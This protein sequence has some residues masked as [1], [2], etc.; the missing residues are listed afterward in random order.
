LLRVNGVIAAAIIIIHL[1]EGKEG[2]KER[3]A[4]KQATRVDFVQMGSLLGF[5]KTRVGTD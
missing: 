3:M 2:R 1:R 4:S 5:A